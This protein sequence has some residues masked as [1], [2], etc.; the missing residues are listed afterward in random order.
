MRENMWR[1]KKKKILHAPTLDQYTIY[2]VRSCWNIINCLEFRVLD[3]IS[4]V[5][6]N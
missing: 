2:I 5:L 4:P 6:Y 1:K 3:I